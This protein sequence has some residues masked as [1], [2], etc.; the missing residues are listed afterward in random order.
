MCTVYSFILS[1]A[2]LVV[3]DTLGVAIGVMAALAWRRS[4]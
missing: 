1:A 2:L 3:T 4:A